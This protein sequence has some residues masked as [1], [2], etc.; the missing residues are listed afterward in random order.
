[1]PNAMTDDELLDLWLACLVEAKN[2]RAPKH[3]TPSNAESYYTV[4]ALRKFLMKV[5]DE[6]L[7]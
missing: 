7:C 4:A 5:D 1:M 3:F 2:R 6:G